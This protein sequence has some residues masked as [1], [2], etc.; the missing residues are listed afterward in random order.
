MDNEYP[1]KLSK[2]ALIARS[3]GMS[4]GKW[5]ALQEPVDVEKE[6]PEDWRICEYCGKPYKPT[7]KRIQKYCEPYC[8]QR[9]RETKRRKALPNGDC[10]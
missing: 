9:A 4:Y 3:S 10:T 8:G 6:I 5:K 7:T 2:E 1:D